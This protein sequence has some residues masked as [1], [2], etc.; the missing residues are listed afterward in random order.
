MPSDVIDS[1]RA[2]AHVDDARRRET[3][4]ATSRTRTRTSRSSA[5]RVER[6]SRERRV[7]G[8]TSNGIA[9]NAS[10]ASNAS[11]SR[12]RGGWKH[13]GRGSGRSRAGA[14]LL[15]CAEPARG[16]RAD[17]ESASDRGRESTIDW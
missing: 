10:V 12:A 2:T 11:R 9:S 5:R 13:S 1:A 7:R 15:W 16:E 3:T 4:R 6:A 8:R 14:F 17:G